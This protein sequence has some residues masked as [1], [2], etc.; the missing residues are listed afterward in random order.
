MECVQCIVQRGLSVYDLGNEFCYPKGGRNA[1][2]WVKHSATSFYDPQGSRSEGSSRDECGLHFLW[3]EVEWLRKGTGEVTFI[4][5]RRM[6]IRI[7]WLRM[8]ADTK[9]SIVKLTKK[10]ALHLFYN[11][12]LNILKVNLNADI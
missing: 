12:L 5:D 11:E 9:Y 4:L 10:V 6:A 1:L 3:H 7:L 8:E 2:K